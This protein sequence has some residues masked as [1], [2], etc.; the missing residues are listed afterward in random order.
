[1][2]ASSV[3]YAQQRW[4]ARMWYNAMIPMKNTRFPNRHMKYGVISTKD[5]IEVSVRNITFTFEFNHQYYHI[6][7]F[8]LMVTVY[9]SKLKLNFRIV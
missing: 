8:I 5:L 2:M 1:M 6:I 4:G 3:A 7:E 9:K